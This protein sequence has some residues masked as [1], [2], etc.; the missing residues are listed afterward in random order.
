MV[1]AII[2]TVTVL[3]DKST[4]TKTIIASAFLVVAFNF[5]VVAIFYGFWASND[6]EF[7]ERHKF[8]MRAYNERTRTRR[9]LRDAQLDTTEERKN[10]GRELN[11]HAS[12]GQSEQGRGENHNNGENVSESEN[13]TYLDMV[14]PKTKRDWVVLAIFWLNFVVLSVALVIN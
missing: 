12:E 1:C 6:Y 10:S 11:Y 13:E 2:Y 8:R 4:A 3:G 5:F 14:A 7:Y 9:Q